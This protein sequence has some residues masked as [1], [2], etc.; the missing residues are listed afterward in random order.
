MILLLLSS[1]CL[2][3][4]L[5]SFSSI[6]PARQRVKVVDKEV[7]LWYRA[8]FSSLLLVLRSSDRM[9]SSSRALLTPSTYLPPP[10]QPRHNLN[11]A[12]THSFKS[13]PSIYVKYI[14]I[15]A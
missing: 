14:C 10:P 12:S 9:A 5:S 3:S 8:A 2:A 11:D 15:H 6:T 4:N 13:P 7:F 1:C